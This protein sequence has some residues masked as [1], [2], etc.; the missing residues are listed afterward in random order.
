MT[1]TEELEIKLA[2][3]RSLMSS[4]KLDAVYLKRQDDFAWLTCGGQSYLGWGEM[5]NCGLLVTDEGQYAVTNLIEYPRMIEEEHL[6][7]MGFKILAAVWFEND[8]E[9][10]TVRRLVPSLN[11]GTDYNAP[12][13][14]KNI[15]GEIKKLRLS[16]TESEQDRLR[17]V[18]ELASLA[19]E[20]ACATLRPGDRE[21]DA[22]KRIADHLFD[23]GM[24]YT[25][26][27]CAADDRLLK[28]RHAIPTENRILRRVQVGG[29]MRKWGLTVC[30]TRYVNFVP[31]TEEL[32]SQYR[33]N[34]RIDLALMTNTHPGCSYQ[35]PLLAARKIYDEN[36]LENEFEKHHQGG[37]I[38]YAN[39]DYRVDFNLNDLIHDDQAFCWNPSIT[40]TKSEDTILVHKEGFEFIT[41]PYVF[42]KVDIEFEGRKYTR[43]D[44]LEKC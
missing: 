3:T 41:R 6:E 28:Y 16:L 9:S 34:Q 26:L 11:I 5:G 42:P 32:R 30:M 37:P 38:G 10:E 35:V 27:M 21:L 36:G 24:E 20:E 7:D 18:G 13:G 40:G 43:A 1:R 31:V 14:G 44:I 29:N 2:R 17:K 39:R 33:L 19:M 23:C 25:S 22:V 15:A 4:M 8:F 12:F